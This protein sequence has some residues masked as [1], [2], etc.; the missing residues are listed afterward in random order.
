MPADVASPELTSPPAYTR[1]AAATTASSASMARSNPSTSAPSR[2]PMVSYRLRS[3]RYS[4]SWISICPLTREVAFSTSS[5]MIPSDHPT[6]NTQ[7]K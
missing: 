4:A 6:T 2:P 5:D 7:A 1:G 3:G